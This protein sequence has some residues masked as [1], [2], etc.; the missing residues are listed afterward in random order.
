MDVPTTF[1]STM[2]QERTRLHDAMK[3]AKARRQEAEDEIASLQAQLAAITA[4][5][6][7]LKGKHVMPTE[8]GAPRGPRGQ[9]RAAILDLIAQHPE[10][11]T[12]ADII[13]AMHAHGDKP[14]TQSISNVLSALK[15]AG[16]VAQEGRRYH[17]GRSDP[18]RVEAGE[19]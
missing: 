1:V 7:A 14:A 9:K 17:A 5:D 4:Y 8:P 15:K 10:G 16:R 6:A 2:A 13:E 3:A 18:S 11:M 19:L 12:R